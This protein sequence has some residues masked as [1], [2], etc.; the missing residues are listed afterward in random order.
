VVVDDVMDE[1]FEYELLHRQLALMGHPLVRKS[2]MLTDLP[3]S[4][5]V[6]AATFTSP[7]APY[8]VCSRHENTIWGVV[9]MD[10]DEWVEQP[11]LR[12]KTVLDSVMTDAGLEADGGYRYAERMYKGSGTKTR[13][14]L[15]DE[16]NKVMLVLSGHWRM[17]KSVEV[18]GF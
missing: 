7:D 10:N 17:P 16:E 6:E 2:M 12:M 9:I 18:F 11:S 5:W 8:V 3:P 14:P 4:L 15:G 1:D 13:G